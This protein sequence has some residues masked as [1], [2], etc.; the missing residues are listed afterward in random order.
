M[1]D[2][3]L[4][5]T[6]AAVRDGRIGVDEACTALAG[7][8]HERLPF[9][10]ID[11]HR[12]LR[13]GQPEVIYC[14][15]KEPE[16]A[17]AIA[18]RLWRRAGLVLATRASEAHAE[19]IRRAV[20]A[21]RWNPVART[22]CAGAPAPRAAPPVLVL[23]AGTSDLPVAEEAVETVRAMGE[24]VEHVVDVGVAGIHRLLERE[25]SL[26]A[27][28]AIVVVAGMDGALP[29]VVAGLVRAPVVAVPTSVG[30]GA[31]FGGLAALLAMLN[32][33]AAGVTVVNI[34]NGLGGGFAAARINRLRAAAAV[35]EEEACA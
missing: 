7:W 6:L 13:N 26:T 33:C 19:A 24:P 31:S 16:Q 22:V 23:T 34:D 28:G 15:G 4:R 25:E 35:G 9:A 5:T 30:Y 17:A 12:A 2:A 18:D 21:A 32:A 27:A 10:T 20:P 1:F 14:P 11:H 29:S 3:L 8:P